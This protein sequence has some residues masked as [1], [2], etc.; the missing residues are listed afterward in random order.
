MS[1]ETQ[2]TAEFIK[3]DQIPL[4]STRILY[5]VLCNTIVKLT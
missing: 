2:A 1:T 3:K 5:L 4:Q